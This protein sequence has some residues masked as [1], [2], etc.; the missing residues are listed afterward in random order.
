MK[1]EESA[2]CTMH[3][4][5]FKDWLQLASA[6]QENKNMHVPIYDAH[7]TPELGASQALLPLLIHFVKFVLLKY[8]NLIEKYTLKVSMMCS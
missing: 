5:D 6:F 2:I 8:R 1:P 3:F 4:E 7:K